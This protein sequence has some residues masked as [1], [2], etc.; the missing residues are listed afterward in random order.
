MPITSE[1]FELQSSK[2]SGKFILLGT[3]LGQKN[4]FSQGVTFILI[5]LVWNAPYTNHCD[6]QLDLIAANVDNLILDARQ[7]PAPDLSNHD[8]L[9]AVFNISSSDRVSK[10]CVSETSKI[11]QMR[12]SLRRFCLTHGKTVI[13][14]TT[15]MT[16]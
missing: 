9:Y 14:L 8:L 11:P 5:D 6:S 15:S 2:N 13:F 10:D 12:S 3:I 7:T 4:N 16:R 1:P